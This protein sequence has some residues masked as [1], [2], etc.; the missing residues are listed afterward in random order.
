MGLFVFQFAVLHL[1]G[2]HCE[3]YTWFGYEN[4]IELRKAVYEEKM[5]RRRE[6]EAPATEMG[7]AN[8][9]EKE[10]DDDGNGDVSEKA[11]NSEGRKAQDGELGGADVDVRDVD[12][13]VD[14]GRQ[15]KLET[16]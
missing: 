1:R 2:P 6:A 8:L 14:E 15:A 13:A 16:V 5:R 12:L 10:S 4:G 9:P 7:G 3:R 11:S